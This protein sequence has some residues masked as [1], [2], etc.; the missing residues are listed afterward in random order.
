M[1]SFGSYT[2]DDQQSRDETGRPASIPGDEIPAVVMT[3][4][5]EYVGTDG[6]TY[7][8]NYIADHNGFQPV[9]AHLP[10]ANAPAAVLRT[11]KVPFGAVRG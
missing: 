8:V 10:V 11:T 9:G 6:V 5:Y 7:T 2:Q 1:H 3:G 4:K